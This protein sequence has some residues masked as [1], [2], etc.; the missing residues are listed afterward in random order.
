MAKGALLAARLIAAVGI[1][2][3]AAAVV[4]GGSHFPLGQGDEPGVFGPDPAPIPVTSSADV[5]GEDLVRPTLQRGDAG[6]WVI[7]LQQE[8]TRNG[9]PVEDDGDFGPVTEAAVRDFQ[10]AHGLTHD[11][12][13]GPQTWAALTGAATV[14]DSSSRPSDVLA[15]A[16]DYNCDL[17]G[18]G[19]PWLEHLPPSK[20]DLSEDEMGVT[21]LDAAH[22]QGFYR[23]T[24]PYPREF[25]YLMW[26]PVEV[27]PGGPSEADVYRILC[28]VHPDLGGSGLRQV[29]A[30]ELDKVLTAFA[31]EDGDA[32]PED[33]GRFLT[34]DVPR[35]ANEAHLG[36]EAIRIYYLPEMPQFVRDHIANQSCGPAAQATTTSTSTT[37]AK[38]SR[39]WQVS[40]S[41]FEFE[42][43]DPYWDITHGRF[44]GG[45]RF[46]YD[47]QAEVVVRREEGTWEFV[48]GEVTYADIR[49]ST[50]YGPDGAWT[51]QEPLTC[52]NCSNMKVGR[53]LTGEVIDGELRLSWGSFE[54]RTIVTAKLELP[55]RPEPSCSAEG[56]NRYVSDQFFDRLNGHLLP[57]AE[58]VVQAPRVTNPQ[59]MLFLDY[60]ITLRLVD[61]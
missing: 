36:R 32:D 2:G 21:T 5:S 13:V 60:T 23:A 31:I 45:V 39:R 4:V 34:D 61:G 53:R 54:P 27:R 57:L 52:D 11:G 41:G 16:I 55:C 56:T 28:E 26:L 29:P 48:S 9:F 44:F 3:A 6:E 33:V 24:T 49:L 7:E 42:E 22:L 47:L 30:G 14:T 25:P 17:A 8:L 20:W 19:C 12:I 35:S 58:G 1:A 43:L 50:R 37:V 40:I 38:E 15:V 59:G 18:T 51:V 10:T 46:G